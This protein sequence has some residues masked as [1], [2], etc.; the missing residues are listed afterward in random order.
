MKLL[1]LFIC[2]VTVIALTGC[3]TM[4]GIKQSVQN[5]KMPDISGKSASDVA[6]PSSASNGLMAAAGAD[7]PQVKALPDLASIS[8][9]ADPIN[10]TAAKMIATTVIDNVGASCQVA[11]NSVSVE[12]SLDFT[13]TLGPVGLKDL[14]GQAN[15]TY[16]YFLTVITPDGQIL[17][18][19]VFALSMVYE[20]KQMTV[21]K[22]DKLR[23]V[24]PLMAG[25]NASQFQI[26]VGFQ[27]SESE[28]SY[29]RSGKK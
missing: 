10:P 27:L 2:A 1:P 21:R 25:Q 11:P 4:N 26:V 14:N 19:D 20:N 28:L 16:P 9:F 15:Y 6:A 12:L 7:C 22:Q 5:I 17:S 8:Q 18:K 23:Q 29:N 3:Q 24:I 13:G